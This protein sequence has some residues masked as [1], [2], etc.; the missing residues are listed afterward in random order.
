LRIANLRSIATL[1]EQTM[2]NRR[3]SRTKGFLI[4]LAATAAVIAIH[5]IAQHLDD[6]AQDVPRTQ[7]TAHRHV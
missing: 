6:S 4:Y 5:A 1:M 2:A 3:F 7:T